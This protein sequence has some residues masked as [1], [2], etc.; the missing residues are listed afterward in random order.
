MFSSSRP[1]DA[2]LQLADERTSSWDPKN[3]SPH[4]CVHAYQVYNNVSGICGMCFS[5]RRTCNAPND[6]WHTPTTPCNH[7]TECGFPL[8]NGNI[9]QSLQPQSFSLALSATSF[10]FLFDKLPCYKH[11][12]QHHQHRNDHRRRHI[13]HSRQPF[14]L[15]EQLQSL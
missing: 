2:L 3:A 9:W 15:L 4:A 13:D 6:G 14:T 12:Q 7:R 11:S 10:K 1:I 8:Y 5:P